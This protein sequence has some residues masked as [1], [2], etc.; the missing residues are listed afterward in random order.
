MTYLIDIR[1]VFSQVNQRKIK[2][3]AGSKR[4][5]AIVVLL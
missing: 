2:K 3:I 5:T 1:I 4:I